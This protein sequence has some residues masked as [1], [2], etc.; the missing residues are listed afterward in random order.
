MD[1]PLDEDWKTLP[2]VYFF[3]ALGGKS[4]KIGFSTNF[5]C[6]LRTVATYC[7]HE[8]MPIAVIPGKQQEERKAHRILRSC[9]IRGE[10]FRDCPQ[11]WNYIERH[12]V[13]VYD[14]WMS[15]RDEILPASANRFVR[16][17]EDLS[18][19]DALVAKEIAEALNRVNLTPRQRD[20]F[21]LR[22]NLRAGPK[23]LEHLGRKYKVTG[24]CIAA[25]DARAQGKIIEDEEI[26]RLIL[27]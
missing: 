4:I 19:H 13:H 10:W 27:Q 20:V 25:I 6:R 23:T 11:V 9:R 8:I 26:R 22:N 7:P 21:E 18:A 15:L 2:H 1:R 3:Y 14:E 24:T 5:D 12:A 17:Y 16:N